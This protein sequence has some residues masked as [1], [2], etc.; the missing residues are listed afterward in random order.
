[1]TDSPTLFSKISQNMSYQ[2]SHVPADILPFLSIL[3][4]LNGLMILINRYKTQNVTHNNDVFLVLIVLFCVFFFVL[5][6]LVPVYISHAH[7]PTVHH[8]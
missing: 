4:Q 1:M 2:N 3:S 5:L 7:T 6:L 8:T